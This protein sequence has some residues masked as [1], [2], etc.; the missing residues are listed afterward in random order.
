M[1]I[2]LFAGPLIL[3]LN[4]VKHEASGPVE[5]I[6]VVPCADGLLTGPQG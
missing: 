2:A 6:T 4:R 1:T 5:S 3:K